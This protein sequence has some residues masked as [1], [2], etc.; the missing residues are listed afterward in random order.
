[1]IKILLIILILVALD[2]I[3]NKT[4]DRFSDENS[5]NIKYIMTDEEIYYPIVDNGQKLEYSRFNYI[6]KEVQHQY[7]KDIMKQVTSNH[8]KILVLGVALGGILINILDKYPKAKVVGV[9]I[10]DEYF[11]LVRTYS[12]TSRLILIKDDAEHYIK[13]SNINMFDIIICDIFDGLSI[14]T[15]VLSKPFLDKINRMILPNGKFVINTI[16]INDNM[17]QNILSKSFTNKKIKH[18]NLEANS[19]YTVFF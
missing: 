9:D 8:P 16:S 1:M 5:N 6:T 18:T 14:P 4:I 17:I 2:T 10:T 12:D 11:D 7:A 15:F 13:N 19:V 3:I